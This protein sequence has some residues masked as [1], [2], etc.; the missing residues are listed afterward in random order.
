[1]LYIVQGILAPAF[2]N[3]VPPV[4]IC[5]CANTDENLKLFDGSERIRAGALLE[6]LI[7]VDARA[8]IFRPEHAGVHE[9]E[10]EELGLVLDRYRSWLSVVVFGE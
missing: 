10:R 8:A 5:P 9:K 3:P 2:E 1:L 6:K 4:S 7:D